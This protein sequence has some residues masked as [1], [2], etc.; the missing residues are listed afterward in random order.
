MWFVWHVRH[1]LAVT[2]TNSGAA[3]VGGTLEK[4]AMKKVKIIMGTLVK[5]EH[6]GPGEVLSVEGKLAR[7]LIH[8]GKAV[9]CAD[10]PKKPMT[11]EPEPE[12]EEVEKPKKPAPKKKKAKK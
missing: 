1:H 7:M 8:S 12:P 3:L 4:E 5:G 11:R 2:S 6:A 10:E 9:P